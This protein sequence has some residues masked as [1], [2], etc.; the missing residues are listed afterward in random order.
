M[1]VKRIIG[2]VPAKFKPEQRETLADA[3]AAVSADY[4][5]LSGFSDLPDD[6][7]IVEH[8]TVKPKKMPIG[9][10]AIWCPSLIVR[11]M[12]FGAFQLYV[13]LRFIRSV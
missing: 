9:T 8:Q 12:L 3:H 2:A 11:R 10:S 1:Q 4:A 7:T 13:R 5:S 6:V